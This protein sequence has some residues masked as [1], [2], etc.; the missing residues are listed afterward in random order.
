MK[1][2]RINPP[3]NFAPDYVTK[4]IAKDNT[5]YTVTTLD[6]ILNGGDGYTSL[7]APS[8]AKVR[9]L[10]VNVFADAIKAD[11]ERSGVV[12]MP[13]PDGRIKKVG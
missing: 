2:L 10:Y 8:I 4:A 11:T 7:F 3:S 12:Q 5:E 6:F 9:D 13:A 1:P